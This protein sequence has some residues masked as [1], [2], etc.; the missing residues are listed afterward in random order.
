MGE[1]RVSRRCGECGSTELIRDFDTGELVCECCGYVLAS[2]SLDHGPEWRSF[3]A[4]QRDRRTRTGAPLT[5]VVHDQGLSTVID[6]RN[7]DSR[8]RRLKPSQRARVYRLR[9]WHRRTKV[10]GSGQK[11][12]A[13]ALSEMMKVSQKLKLP[14]RVLETASMI[15]R[16]IVRKRLTRGHSIKGM[17]AA[18][19]YMACRKCRVTRTI[20]EVAMTA[21]MS[22]KECGRNYRHL[23]RN[24]DI[25]IPQ[26]DP[27]EYISKF[28]SSLALSGKAESIALDLLDQAVELK[29]TSGRGP[30]GIAAAC[31]YMACLLTDEPRTQGEIAKEASMTEVTIRNRYKELAQELDITMM[32]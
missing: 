14:K 9:K 4:E 30:T 1:N 13:Y 10:S 17:A 15:Y 29:L 12:L 24:L 2:T 3:N 22:K 18:T 19:I 23:L 26:V 11:N 31:T 5:L 6:W 16:K 27:Q 32:L 25:D 20:E 21:S 7:R 28:A 8:G